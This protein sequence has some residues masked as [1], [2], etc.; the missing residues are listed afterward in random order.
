MEQ[1]IPNTR[2]PGKIVLRLFLCA[3]SWW[4]ES[5]IAAEFDHDA[6]RFPLD[7][8]HRF[9]ECEVCHINGRFK[10]TPKDCRSCHGGSSLIPGGGKSMHHILSS[11]NCADCHSESAWAQVTRFDHSQVIGNCYSCHNGT[12]QTGKPVNH[13]VS[14]NQCEACHNTLTWSVARFDHS[15][16]TAVCSSCHNGQIATG[17]PGDHINTSAEC[18]QCHSTR[19]WTPASFDHS[20]ITGSCSSCHNGIDATGKDSSHFVTN[21]ECDYCHNTSSWSISRFIH[22]SSAYPGDHRRS[23]DCDDCHRSNSETNVWRYPAYQ[24]DCAACHANEYESDEHKKVDSPTIFY[25]V[26]E[27]RDCSGACHVY[28]D[29]SLTEIG[30]FR[31]SQHRITDSEFDD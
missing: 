2:L 18:D 31:S 3:V 4:C 7:G 6:T 22:Q 1:R 15:G 14:S 28:K 26:S 29:A 11:D 16:I 23:L 30:D 9:V 24:P 27:L 12:Q 20:N 13:V 5:L 19:G 17:K 8:F 21:R 10:G 25:N